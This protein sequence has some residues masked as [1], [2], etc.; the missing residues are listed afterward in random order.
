[1]EKHEVKERKI[2]RKIIGPIFQDNKVVYIRNETLYKKIEKLL[3]TI[4]KR[5]IN[6]YGHL[7]MNPNRSTK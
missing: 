3:D 4:R 6:F 2:L 5:W 7:R 1:M